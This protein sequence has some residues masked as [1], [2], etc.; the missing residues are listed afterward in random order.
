[1]EQVFYI[2]I[3]TQQEGLNQKL[4]AYLVLTYVHIEVYTIECYNDSVI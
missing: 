1:M 2:D 4:K 3:L